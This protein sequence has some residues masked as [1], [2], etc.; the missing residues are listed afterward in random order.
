M[1]EEMRFMSKILKTGLININKDFNKST[2]SLSVNKKMYKKY[3]FDYLTSKDINKKLNH[4]II[5]SILCK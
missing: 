1:L 2:I 3:K 4:E 5:N